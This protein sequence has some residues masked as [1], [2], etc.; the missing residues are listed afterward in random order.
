MSVLY[1]EYINDLFS[2]TLT[3]RPG[4]IEELEKAILDIT[5]NE[6]IID[7]S[8]VKSMSIEFAEEYL[9]IKHEIRQ[10]IARGNAWLKTQQKPGGHWDDEG[11]PAFTALALT[12]AS[13]DPNLDRKAPFPEHMEKGFNWLLAQQKPDGGIYNRGL[14]VYNTATAVTAMQTAQGITSI[15]A[16]GG[17]Y[18]VAADALTVACPA[19]IETLN[20]SE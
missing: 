20:A 2:P 8:G 13:R 16:D 11:T 18:D 5:Y 14:T 15:F 7:F 6:I 1:V 12:A 4:I 3:L 19:E 10:S 17:S 9:S